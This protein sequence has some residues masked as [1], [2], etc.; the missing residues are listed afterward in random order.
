MVSMI[1][2]ADIVIATLLFLAIVAGLRAGLF[3]TLGAFV[4]VVAGALALVIAQFG[5]KAQAGHNGGR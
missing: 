1:P 5:R 3:S 2:L 4:G